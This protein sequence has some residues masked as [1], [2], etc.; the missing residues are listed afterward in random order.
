MAPGRPLTPSS[1]RVDQSA[2]A[3]PQEKERLRRELEATDRRIDEVVYQLYG[4]SEEEIRV[5]EEAT[6]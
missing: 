3:H 5:V 1:V 6:V 4:L 2:A